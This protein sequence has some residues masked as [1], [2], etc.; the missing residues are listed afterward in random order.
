MEEIDEIFEAGVG[1]RKFKQYQ[2]RIVDEVRNDVDARNEK[3]GATYVS[4]VE[5]NA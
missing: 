2:C 5:K 1:A 4:N 3:N